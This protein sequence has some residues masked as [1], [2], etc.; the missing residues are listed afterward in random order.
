M[1]GTPIWRHGKATSRGVTGLPDIPASKQ[2]GVGCCEHQWDTRNAPAQPSL[3]RGCRFQGDAGA[4]QILLPSLLS[5]QHLKGRATIAIGL[6]QP[7]GWPMP[8]P[9]L[10]RAKEEKSTEPATRAHKDIQVS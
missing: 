3:M 10:G 6:S 5:S 9:G 8:Y 1:L 7:Q 4:A 2:Q